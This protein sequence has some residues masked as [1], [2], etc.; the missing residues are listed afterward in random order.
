MFTG[1]NNFHLLFDGTINIYRF[2]TNLFKIRCLL[3]SS[4]NF[5]YLQLAL[6]AIGTFCYKYLENKQTIKISTL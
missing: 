5:F 1:A 3:V 4:Y 6:S 2:Y